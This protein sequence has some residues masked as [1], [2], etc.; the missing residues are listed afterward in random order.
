MPK[1]YVLLRQRILELEKEIDAA[2]TARHAADVAAAK[3]MEQDAALA[4]CV[5][6]ERSLEVLAESSTEQNA[7]YPTAEYLTAGLAE[8]Y[9][10]AE[11]AR[12]V[13][14]E[15]AI[16]SQRERLSHA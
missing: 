11:R 9:L 12:G 16:Q 2:T 14:T 4:S 6:A 1:G 8:D 13:S 7:E 15:A 5:A 10:A 3:T